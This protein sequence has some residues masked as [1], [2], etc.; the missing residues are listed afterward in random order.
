MIGT[1]HFSPK[2]TRDE[3][4][5]KQNILYKSCCTQKGTPSVTLKLS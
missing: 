5:L 3:V 4:S 1:G 2:I